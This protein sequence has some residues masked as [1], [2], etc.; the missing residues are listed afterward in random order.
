MHDVAASGGQEQKGPYQMVQTDSSAACE[1]QMDPWKK[2]EIFMTFFDF[3]VCVCVCVCE[4]NECSSVNNA[5]IQE[6][7]LEMI[8]EGRLLTFV[9]DNMHHLDKRFLSFLLP[10]GPVSGL[11]VLGAQE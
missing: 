11:K 3:C 6:R 8:Q 9:K 1:L 2:S 4:L 5:H 10:V 7:K